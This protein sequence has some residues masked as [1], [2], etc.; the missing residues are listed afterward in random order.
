MIKYNEF[1]AII[2]RWYNCIVECIAYKI[3]KIAEGLNKL[4]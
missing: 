1:V 4:S 2:K 3:N